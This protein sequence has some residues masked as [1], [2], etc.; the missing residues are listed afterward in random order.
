[1]PCSAAAWVAVATAVSS[2]CEPARLRSRTSAS[3]GGS[4]SARPIRT[5]WATDSR[6]LVSTP[7]VSAMVMAP[8]DGAATIGWEDAPDCGRGEVDVE[9]AGC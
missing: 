8:R 9:P 2:R 3:G 7:D 6:V 4:S 1:M 5:L